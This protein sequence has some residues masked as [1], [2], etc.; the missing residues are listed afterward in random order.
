MSTTDM[1]GQNL[2]KYRA[3]GG[4]SLSLDE[5]RS[6]QA[7]GPPGPIHR[8]TRHPRRRCAVPPRKHGGGGGR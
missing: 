5:E 2:K 7:P 8:G 1:M 6:G 3:P 4:D